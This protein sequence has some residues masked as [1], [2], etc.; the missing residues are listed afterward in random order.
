MTTRLPFEIIARV[1]FG[2]PSHRVSWNDGE[3]ASQ[4]IA[5]PAASTDA[6]ATATANGD[7]ERTMRRAIVRP[8]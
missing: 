3:A 7:R 6:S 8:G 1:R 4:A 2:D 5:S